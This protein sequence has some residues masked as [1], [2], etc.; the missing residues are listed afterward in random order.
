MHRRCNLSSKYGERCACSFLFLFLVLTSLAPKKGWVNH[1][2]GP[3]ICCGRLPTSESQSFYFADDHP[4]M[5]SWFKG[6]E[7]IIVKCGLWPEGGLP[8][9]CHKF[10]CPPSHVDC[11]CQHV[12]FIQPDF[13]DQRSQLQELIEKH[14]HLC[15][16]TP[17]TTANG[18]LS[19]STGARPRLDIASPP[20]Q[21]QF[22]TWRRASR[23]PLMPS[24][25][26]FRFNG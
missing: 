14:C 11:C 5:P 7:Q 13:T 22:T 19:S 15:N 12:L 3:H 6:M 9:H 16:S 4:S 21:R 2:G 24:L 8:A 17:T 20:K 10:K 26:F 23:T 1:A 18:T 25:F